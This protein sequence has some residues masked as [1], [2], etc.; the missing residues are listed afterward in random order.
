MRTLHIDT[1][2]EMQ[3]GQWQVLYLVERLR[4]AI[5]LADGPLLHEARR[6][7]IES[8][9][10]SLSA[11][12]GGARKTDL[13]HAHD[14]RAHTMACTVPGAKLVVS[15][16]V[17]FPVNRGMLSKLKYGHADLFLAVSRYVAT[18]LATAQ[19]PPEK[20]RVVYDGVPLVPAA[21]GDAI[22]ALTG[23]AEA[24][25]AGLPVRAVTNLWQ[26]LAEA[27]IFIYPSGMEG[28]GSA[29]LAAMSASIPVIAS[30]VGGLPEA[31]EHE[32]T[33]I[34]VNNHA[35]DFAFALS[36]LERSPHMAEEMGM[37]GRERVEQNFT[38][39][40]MVEKTKQAYQEVLR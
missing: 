3:G 26:D 21:R 14:A 36:R 24:M 35:E 34:L 25:L 9:P 28:L 33:G 13:V 23:K 37:R 6:R 22:V 19:I 1:G 12:Q 10:V 11:I 31:V 15:R 5:L 32:R 4:N 8:Q 20:I 7:G 27:R 39:E 18:Q 40:I 16:R 29:A 30:N 17:A 2:R 38:I